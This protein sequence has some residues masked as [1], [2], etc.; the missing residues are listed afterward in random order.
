MSRALLREF[1]IDMKKINRVRNSEIYKSDII[2]I[3]IIDGMKYILWYMKMNYL[4]IA[5]GIRINF[6]G[7]LNE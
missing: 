6:W 3:R 7:A 4:C 2:F 5:I 1:S